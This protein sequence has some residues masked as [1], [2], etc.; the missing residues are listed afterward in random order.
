MSY[1]NGE[2]VKEEYIYSFAEKYHRIHYLELD[3]V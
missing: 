2:A 3:S 1:V